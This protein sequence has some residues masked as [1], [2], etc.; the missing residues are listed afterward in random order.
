MEATDAIR[1]DFRQMESH[2]A[3]DRIGSLGF[4]APTLLPTL[5]GTIAAIDL[6]PGDLIVGADGDLLRVVETR[7]TQSSARQVSL[8]CSET[9][10][11]I[12]VGA[13]QMVQCRHFLTAALFGVYRPIMLAADIASCHGHDPDI[14][15]VPLVLPV[16]ETPGLVNVRGY[17]FLCPGLS[18]DASRIDEERAE[19]GLNTDMHRRP[20]FD[21]S[22]ANS[23]EFCPLLTPLQVRQ[24]SEAGVLRGS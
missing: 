13:S 14:L 1:F 24:L 5:E 21:A 4:S 11:R 10:E 19:S 6:K 12:V 9:G 3:D 8:L 15:D 2:D 17:L 22:E 7:L 16:F 23:H 20:Q 18:N